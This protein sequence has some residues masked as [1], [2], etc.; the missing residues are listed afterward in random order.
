MDRVWVRC[1]EAL[2]ADEWLLIDECD[3]DDS[4]EFESLAREVAG[5]IWNLL[6]GSHRGGPITIVVQESK[7]GRELARVRV[8]RIVRDEFRS[9]LV[10][11][12]GT[13]SEESPMA[14]VRNQSRIGRAGGGV[15]RPSGRPSD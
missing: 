8:T 15:P 9:E 4:A 7:D 14:T 12:P 3:A 2:Y 13:G 5:Q 6:S 10:G 1:E 11:G